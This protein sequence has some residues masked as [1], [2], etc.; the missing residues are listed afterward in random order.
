MKYV[1][2]ASQKLLALEESIS[3]SVASS[4]VSDK[5]VA[6]VVVASCKCLEAGFVNLLLAM[7]RVP[8]VTR[9]ILQHQLISKAANGHRV[10]IPQCRKLVFEYC[11]RS[12]SSTRTRTWLLNS[13]EEIAKQNP[14]VEVVVKP[15]SFKEPI[16]RGFYRAC[17]SAMLWVLVHLFCSSE[18]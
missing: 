10:F 2:R 4:P 3:L 9:P 14:H 17:S 15:R 11:E 16:V 18:R 13:V 8:P 1:A 5:V 7:Q 12:K 6:K